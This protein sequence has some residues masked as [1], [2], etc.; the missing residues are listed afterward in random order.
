MKFTTLAGIDI[1]SNA[2][3]FMINNIE[4]SGTGDVYKKVAY[5]RIPL[6]LGEDVFTKGVIGKCKAQRFR[7]TMIGLNHL[8]KGYNV[9]RYMACATSAMRDAGNGQELLDYILMSTGMDINIIS[10][11]E[12]ARMILE[13]SKLKSFLDANGNYLYMDVG[14]GSTEI[15]VRSGHR[16]MESYSFQIGTIR[17]LNNVVDASEY[18]FFDHWLHEVHRKYAPLTLIASGG[19]INKAYK[20]T[21]YTGGKPVPL[22]ELRTLYTKLASLSFDQRMEKYGLNAYRADVIVPALQLFVTVGDICGITTC[23]VPQTG[24]VDGI[25]HHLYTLSK[26][27]MD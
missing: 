20:L 21:G 25:I 14:G 4:K 6:R 2:I 15:T 22:K 5:L 17:M 1:G 13:A 9:S 23:F 3:R 11:Q 7:E 16:A 27:D 26:N 24:L 18:A 12:E 10:G 19:N 8:M